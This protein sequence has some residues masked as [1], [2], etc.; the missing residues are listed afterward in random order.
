MAPNQIGLCMQVQGKSVSRS[1]FLQRFPWKETKKDKML[2]FRRWNHITQKTITSAA[3]NVAKTSLVRKKSEK[4]KPR[5]KNGFSF[6]SVASLPLLPNVTRRG[7]ENKN[8]QKLHGMVGSKLTISKIFKNA[9]KHDD[10]SERMNRGD[11]SAN[12]ASQNA[13]VSKKRKQLSFSKSGK[14]KV[15]GRLG[16]SGRKKTVK[17][18]DCKSALGSHVKK[19][20]LSLKLSRPKSKDLRQETHEDSNI[21]QTTH[22]PDND[23]PLCLVSQ[24]EPHLSTNGLRDQKSKNKP[25]G[26]WTVFPHQRSPSLLT[27]SPRSFS[28]SNSTP[29]QTISRSKKI[30]EKTLYRASTAKTRQTLTTSSIYLTG[31]KT[32]FANH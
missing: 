30:T 26:N 5:I 10:T 2:A 23:K 21:L 1:E 15:Q 17:K 9:A 12:H 28:I 20:D 6:R 19:I 7:D 27:S 16:A 4:R 32:L 18:T 31:K 14:T 29:N 3:K 11:M 24:I 22:K 13:K 25:T 8:E